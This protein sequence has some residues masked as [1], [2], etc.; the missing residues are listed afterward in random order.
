MTET[1][2]HDIGQSHSGRFVAD[3]RRLGAVDVSSPVLRHA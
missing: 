1:P 3:E 2:D